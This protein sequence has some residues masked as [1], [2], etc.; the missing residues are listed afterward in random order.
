[1]KYL[2]TK[3]AA[4]ILKI[5]PVTIRKKIRKGKIKA[6]KK[7]NRYFILKSEINKIIKIYE[8]NPQ[9]YKHRAKYFKEE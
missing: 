1:M 5:K 9:T 3:E 6:T 8:K 2:T 4:K 7:E